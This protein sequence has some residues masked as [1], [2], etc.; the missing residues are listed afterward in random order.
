M[1]YYTMLYYNS[2]EDYYYFFY[3]FSNIYYSILYVYILFF[4]FKSTHVYKR[5]FHWVTGV[6][7][8]IH[9]VYKLVV[10]PPCSASASSVVIFACGGLSWMTNRCFI[11]PQQGWTNG[12][13][14]VIQHSNGKW[15][16]W[17]CI[18]LLKMGIC[19]WNVSLPA[20]SCWN[21]TCIQKF[22]RL[23]NW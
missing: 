18:F 4:G 5:P 7:T 21:L 20:G 16:L 13:T 1:L 2:L 19:H 23:V 15:T 8:P 3:V 9:A 17:R 22:W 11:K 10:S 6:I 12:Y 14:P